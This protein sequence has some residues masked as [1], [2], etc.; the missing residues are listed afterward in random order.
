MISVKNGV[1]VCVV[2]TSNYYDDVFE[3]MLNLADEHIKQRIKKLQNKQQKI[4]SLV[5][6]VL[7]KYMIKSVFKIDF[8]DQVISFEKNGKLF[9]KD[10]PHIHF[11]ISHSEDFVACV[12]ADKRVGIDIQKII[13]AKDNISKYVF[14]EITIDLINNSLNKDLEFTK[15]WTKLEAYLKLKG[16]GFVGNKK[17]FESNV[18]WEFAYVGDYVICVA[19]AN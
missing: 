14:N 19:T 2:N 11:N 12:V 18:K 5:G 17:S 7:R 6:N 3:V 13:P 16:T 4:N 15:Q 10:Y 9:L 1:S 8:K